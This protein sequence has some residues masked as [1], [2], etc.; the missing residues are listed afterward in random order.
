[1][2][3]SKKVQVRLKRAIADLTEEGNHCNIGNAILENLIIEA[4]KLKEE[5][6]KTLDRKKNYFIPISMFEETF[7][8]VKKH[9]AE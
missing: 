5:E 4:I 2:K 9:L 6:I 8:I 3:K 7:Q 1:M